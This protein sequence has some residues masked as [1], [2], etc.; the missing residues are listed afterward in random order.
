MTKLRMRDELG[1]T[2]YRNRGPWLKGAPES[3]NEVPPESASQSREEM[4]EEILWFKENCSARAEKIFARIRT[5]G[6]KFSR[7][8]CSTNRYRYKRSRTSSRL[9]ALV[10]SVRLVPSAIILPLTKFSI[11][12][13]GHFYNC[14]NGHT[15]VITEV[16]EMCSVCP[17]FCVN[18]AFVVWWRH[19]SFDVPRMSS[20]NRRRQSPVSLASNTRAVEFEQLA[21]GSGAG[22]NPWADVLSVDILAYLQAEYFATLVD[23]NLLGYQTTASCFSTD[24]TT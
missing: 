21:R 10:R 19:G 9:S 6:S 13:A 14:P 3:K 7:R 18:D 15:F 12:H 2:S 11:G 20:A 16:R 23:H 8:R 24:I 5:F 4:N 22:A 17:D 1:Y